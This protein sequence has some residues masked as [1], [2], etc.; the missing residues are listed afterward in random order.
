[1]WWN[2]HFILLSVSPNAMPANKYATTSASKHPSI[3]THTVN[4]QNEYCVVT[5]SFTLWWSLDHE[6]QQKLLYGEIH[7][8]MHSLFHR[9]A[10][11]VGGKSSVANPL[12]KI[13]SNY[14][15]LVGDPF[16][17]KVTPFQHPLC[18]SYQ[19]VFGGFF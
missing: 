1:M 4:T 10:W 3:H 14:Q 15:H 2:T 7:D 17:I 19:A 9:P 18:V 16:L 8:F 12:P 5:I 13:W 11:E 6:L